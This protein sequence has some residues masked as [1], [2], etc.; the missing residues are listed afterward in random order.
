M[1]VLPRY[2]NEEP[3]LPPVEVTPDVMAAHDNPQSAAVPRTD[4]APPEPTESPVPH[5]RECKAR[6]APYDKPS[7]EEVQ[8]I[9]E[10]A[11]V[12]L[13]STQDY[14]NMLA[15]AMLSARRD[16]A[17]T[18]ELLNALGGE[19]ATDPLVLWTGLSMC[20]GGSV[21]C[22]YARVAANVRAN[23]STNAA[24]WI[25]LAGNDLAE[26]RE[27]D[28]LE[29]INVALSAPG[30]DGYFAERYLLLDRAFAASTNWSAAERTLQIVEHFGSA[31]PGF[32]AV[33]AQCEKT[34]A[35]AWAP[36]CDQLAAKLKVTNE[37]MG[38]LY[39]YEL[40]LKLLEARGQLEEIA[41]LRDGAVQEALGI[42]GDEDLMAA[43]ANLLFNDEMVLSRF[44]RDI[45]SV[46]EIEAF[47]QLTEEVK[48]LQSSD[49]YD[50]CRFIA[51]P[52]LDI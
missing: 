48:R 2:M 24:F 23:H 5:P 7:K 14:E 1:F 18:V 35:V 17:T 43:T 29:A 26:G 15:A 20:E 50:E 46:G 19:D 22:D 47:R 33:M 45:E 52:Y 25:A 30:F 39:A 9:I 37:L 8:R 36:L 13:R 4:I 42:Q 27:N 32:R 6:M 40:Q 44:L 38:R 12:L 28:A 31:P 16:T 41:E 3:A 21:G 51:N 11:V 49:G 34:E 10:E